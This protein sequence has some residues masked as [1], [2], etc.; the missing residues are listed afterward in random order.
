MVAAPVLYRSKIHWE[1]VRKQ[2][3]LVLF[4]RTVDISKVKTLGVGKC[5]FN[6]GSKTTK[7]TLI[8]F[9]SG[10]LLNRPVFSEAGLGDNYESVSSS[11][12]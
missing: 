8:A 1:I 11:P 3:G 12:E 4:L 6:S 7:K 10:L 5:V 2:R 9:V